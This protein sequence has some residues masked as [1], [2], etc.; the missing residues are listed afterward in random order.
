MISSLFLNGRGRHPNWER[1]RPRPRPVRMQDAILTCRENALA[2]TDLYIYSLPSLLLSGARA[3]PLPVIVVG[4]GGAPSSSY[5]CRGRGRPLSQL[6]LSGARAPP[7]PVM[8][9]GGEGAPSS[10]YG[11]RGRGRPLSQL[12]V[13]ENH[14]LLEEF[15]RVGR[16][17]AE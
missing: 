15:C 4:G 7:L 16:F 1:G 17:S 8:V 5:G 9:V 3:P 10:S 6:W 11:C 12:G 2:P 14:T 13:Y